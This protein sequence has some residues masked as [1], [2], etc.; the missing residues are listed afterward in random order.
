MIPP[1]RVISIVNKGQSNKLVWRPRIIQNQSKAKSVPEGEQGP[2]CA[3]ALRRRCPAQVDH[4]AVP[5]DASECPEEDI[6]S[7]A[8]PNAAMLQ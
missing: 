4:S 6:I 7:A 5:R 1:V 2:Q 8:T 3:E